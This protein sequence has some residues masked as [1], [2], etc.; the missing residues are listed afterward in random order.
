MKPGQNPIYLGDR[1]SRTDLLRVC[2]IAL[3]L[4]FM[5]LIYISPY[6]PIKYYIN[7]DAYNYE[8]IALNI[9]NHGV[10]SNELQR[11]YTPDVLRTPLYPTFLAV[12]YLFCD[13]SKTAVI[14]FQIILG[15]LTVGLTYLFSLTLLQSRTVAIFAALILALDPLTIM[16]A[17]MLMTETLFTFF[18]V[19][20]S[21]AFAKYFQSPRLIWLFVSAA[22]FACAA[23]TRPISQYLPLALLPLISLAAISKQKKSASLR[24][25]LFVSVYFVLIFVWII[26]NNYVAGIWT[27]SGIGESTLVR[28]TARAV[29]ETAE[30]LDSG[31]SK[32]RIESMILAPGNIE[33]SSSAEKARRELQVAARIFKQYPLATV[34]VYREGMLRWLASPG[35]DNICVQLSRVGD[36]NGCKSGGGKT[37]ANFIRKLQLKFGEMDS[38]QLTMAVWS[39]FFLFAM[40]VLSTIGVYRLVKHRQ[41]YELFSLVIIIAYFFLLSAGGQT[42]SRF[43]VP[44]IP[45]WS[46]L[47][48]LGLG[49]IK[50]QLAIT[51]RPVL[52]S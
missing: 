48:G 42:T 26:R 23:L 44:T 46:V 12:V 10:F 49:W 32:T 8:R 13:S 22:M 18:L 21:V 6:T 20:G 38:V 43:R 29:L 31:E 11:P 14:L 40:Y 50:S 45:Y 33:D 5:L 2:I 1:I 15:S 39:T 51:R 27:L 34:A 16:Y 37:D 24:G 28:Y 41:W 19:A 3:V 52:I 9:I 7:P 25:L 17:N 47:A 35:L 4:R 30:D 36:V